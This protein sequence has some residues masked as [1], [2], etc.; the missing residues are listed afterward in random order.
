VV[1]VRVKKPLSSGTTSV[2]V[3]PA[4]ARPAAMS[5]TTAASHRTLSRTGYCRAIATRRRSSGEMR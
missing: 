4:W 2:R 1:S 3:S 5:P